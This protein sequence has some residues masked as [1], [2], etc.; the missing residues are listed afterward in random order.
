MSLT[1]DEGAP[2]PNPHR[3]R[4]A[5]VVIA[6]LIVVFY[7]ARSLWLT[8]SVAEGAVPN[9]AAVPLPRGAEIV[10]SEVSCA[11][12]GCR[13]ILHVR[14]PEGQTPSDLA[15]QIGAT[16]TLRIA[17]NLFE[18]RTTWITAT[19]IGGVLELDLDYWS[20]DAAP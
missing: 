7:V 3:L 9:A 14:P 19:E 18:P 10:S 6:V 2:A 5:I 4:T 11:S 12:G 20:G 16:P 13:H 8:A 1:G 17:P 15:E